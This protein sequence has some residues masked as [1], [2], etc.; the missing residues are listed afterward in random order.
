MRKRVHNGKRGL[1]RTPKGPTMHS[2]A[3]KNTLPHC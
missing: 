2:F 1:Q 3:G